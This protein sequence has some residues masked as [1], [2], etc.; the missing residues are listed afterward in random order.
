MKPTVLLFW[1]ENPVMSPVSLIP[2][3]LVVLP[4][5]WNVEIAPFGWRR[6]ETFLP[7]TLSA[8]PTIWPA[9][10][11]PCAMTVPAAPGIAMSVNTFVAGSY[12]NPMLETTVPG[13]F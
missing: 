7:P 6:N 10:L 4:L 3:A 2:R 8:L 12:R 13:G 11:I 1:K 9:V 5:I